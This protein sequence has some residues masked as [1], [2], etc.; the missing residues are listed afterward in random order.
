[1]ANKVLTTRGA[2]QVDTVQSKFGTGSML[3]TSGS[4]DG[5]DTPDHADWTFGASDFT[6]EA[7]IRFSSVP[8]NTKILMCHRSDPTNRGWD[9]AYNGSAE[10]DRLVFEYS[11]DGSAV[12]TVGRDWAA[13]ANTWYHIAVCR[14]GNNLRLFV[15]GTQIG[16]TADVTGITIFN[17]TEILAIGNMVGIGDTIDGWLDEIRI[18]STARYTANFTAPTSE[19]VGDANT[20]LLVHCNGTDTGTAFYDYGDGNYYPDPN[21]E[22]TTVDG[23]VYRIL[24]AGSGETLATLRQGA[25]NG[26]ADSNPSDTF[27]QWKA[28]TSGTGYI[29]N[30]TPI[31]GFDASA[32]PDTDTISTAIL[33]LCNNN[34]DGFTNDWGANNHYVVVT[35]SAPATPTALVNGDYSKPTTTAASGLFAFADWGTA[36]DETY[37]DYTLNAAGIANI[38]KTAASWFAIIFE[39]VRAEALEAGLSYANGNISFSYVNY[40]EQTGTTKDP[41]LVITHTSVSGPVNLKT[42]NGLAKA[43]VKTING[44]AIASVKTVNGLS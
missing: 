21:I 9:F 32:I 16:A 26:S 39:S 35:S 30:V 34:G 22:A 38:S 31:L 19:F 18:S 12:T 15:D 8:T 11:T 4:T 14:D 3:L 41:K 40:A 29:Q 25:G 2:A 27:V 44:L 20:I 24:S 17:S 1:M 7:Q 33:S 43:S 6:I 28:D 37:L 23:L 42:W 5:I 10:P 13:S 36:T